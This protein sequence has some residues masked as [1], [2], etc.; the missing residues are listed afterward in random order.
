MYI[1]VIFVFPVF[2]ISTS[3]NTESLINTIGSNAVL[4]I[5]IFANGSGFIVTVSLLSSVAFSPL[6]SVT[7]TFTKLIVSPA[8][9][10]EKFKVNVVFSPGISKVPPPKNTS[11]ITKPGDV[12]VGG[13]PNVEFVKFIKDN[14]RKQPDEYAQ[15]RKVN[16]GLLEVDD[17]DQ[18]IMDLGKNEC[19]ASMYAQQSA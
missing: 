18:E 2:F 9:N 3:N 8:A 11:Q 13:R 4:F 19:A 17:E 10:E 1:F 5:E 16:A 6:K 15:I 7:V 12:L 14:M